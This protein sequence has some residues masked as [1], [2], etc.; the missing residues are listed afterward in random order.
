MCLINELQINLMGCDIANYL[1]EDIPFVRLKSHNKLPFKD[2]NF[3]IIMFNDM[4]HHTSF[5]NQEKLITEG[6]RIAKKIVIFEVNPTILGNIFDFLLNKIHNPRM[7]IPLTFRT[8]VEW[9]N[10]FKKMGIKYQD[11]KVIR[12]LFYPFL[13]IGFLLKK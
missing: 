11:K 12:P 8:A 10:L 4:L 3:D 1:V 5:E 6:L 7:A 9:H 2:R 13:H